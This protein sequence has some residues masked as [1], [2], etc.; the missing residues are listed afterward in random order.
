MGSNRPHIPNVKTPNSLNPAITAFGAPPLQDYE[1]TGIS[2]GVG[3]EDTAYCG[4]CEWLR[5]LWAI[6][7]L[8]VG[9]AVAV[10]VGVVVEAVGRGCWEEE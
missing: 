4:S 8:V 5:V 9:R 1:P 6:V 7:V 2:A 3:V 10:G